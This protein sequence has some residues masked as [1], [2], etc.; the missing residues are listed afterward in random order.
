MVRSLRAHDVWLV[1]QAS[2]S[3]WMEAVLEALDDAGLRARV[4]LAHRRPELARG[5]I[6]VELV[7]SAESVPSGVV[8]VD[9]RRMRVSPVEL[10][11]EARQAVAS[12]LRLLTQQSAPQ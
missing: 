7:A 12:V 10:Q 3:H 5:R 1:Y 11:R 8:A 6:I 4:E 9:L 2:D